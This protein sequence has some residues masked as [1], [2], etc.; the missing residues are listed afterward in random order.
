MTEANDR[1]KITDIDAIEAIADISGEVDWTNDE[2][3]DALREDGVDPDKLLKNVLSEVKLLK[4]D[5]ERSDLAVQGLKE[6]L[7]RKSKEA[8]GPLGSSLTEPR[9]RAER[10][11]TMD[12]IVEELR[13]LPDKELETLLADLKA[14]HKKS[15]DW[16]R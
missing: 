5:I 11:K 13:G 16:R 8:I 1:N 2:L 4:S 9:R 6:I 3:R 14:T 7:G 10:R 15:D 12:R